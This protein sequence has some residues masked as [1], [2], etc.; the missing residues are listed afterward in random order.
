MT[1]YGFSQQSDGL[2]TAVNTATGGT[3][4][5]RVNN[6]DRVVMDS[7]GNVTANGT[8]STPAVVLNDGTNDTEIAGIAGFADGPGIEVR[9]L[10]NPADNEPI[11]RVLSS[12]GSERLRIV[13]N[14]TNVMDNSLS[15]TKDI[16]AHCPSDMERIGGD[17]I[18][19]A[20]AGSGSF[21][22]ALQSCA[23]RGRSVCSYSQLVACDELSSLSGSGLGGGSTSCAAQ[24]DNPNAVIWT[25]D[26]HTER[27]DFGESWTVNLVCFKGNDTVL[28]CNKAD[29]HTVFCC[30][31]GI[32]LN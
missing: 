11:F 4:R 32:N 5:L 23:S 29:T 27:D 22:A 8:V 13:H 31:H 17:C 6:V 1:S 28:E 2:L 16:T 30:S 12:G 3:I 20:A 9:P 7:S 10:V 25:S 19:K 15:V 24:T 14:G 18:E 26:R 21:D